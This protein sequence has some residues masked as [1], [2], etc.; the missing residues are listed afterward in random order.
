MTYVERHDV[1]NAPDRQI[2]T[3]VSS[4]RWVISPGQVIAG[5]LGLAMGAIAIITLARAGID[6]SMNDPIVRAGAFDQSALVGAIELGLALLLV[7]GALSY[8]ARGLVAFVGIIMIL[9]GVFLGAAG[10]TLLHDVG[11]VHGTGWAIMVAGIVALVAGSLGRIIKTRRSV[12]S[13]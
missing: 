7:L 11:T 6:S 13:V 12:T 4:A 5:A 3:R 10:S 1:V 2:D 8:A 9:G